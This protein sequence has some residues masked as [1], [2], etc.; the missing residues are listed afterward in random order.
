M[1]Y[2]SDNKNNELSTNVQ[3]LSFQLVFEG[4]S[5]TSSTSGTSDNIRWY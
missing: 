5:K 2:P 3:G 4:L 1:W